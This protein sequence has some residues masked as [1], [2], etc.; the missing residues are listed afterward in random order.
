MTN[1]EV[2]L[3]LLLSTIFA[4]G[5][6]L[7]SSPSCELFQRSQCGDLP[8]CSTT[9]YKGWTCV[10]SDGKDCELVRP[11][12]FVV[13][14]KTPMGCFD[15]QGPCKRYFPW[16]ENHVENKNF[17]LEKVMKCLLFKHEAVWLAAVRLHRSSRIRH[18][19]FGPLPVSPLGRDPRSNISIEKASLQKESWIRALL[20]L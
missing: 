3:F 6:F 20:S 12:R 11:C 4:L 8:I 10:D 2:L 13:G 1:G 19:A 7:T 5:V 18:A 16:A 17:F 15:G 14:C 9:G